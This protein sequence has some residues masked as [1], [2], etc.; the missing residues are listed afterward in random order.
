MSD[1]ENADLLSDISRTTALLS[2]HVGEAETLLFWLDA[3]SAEP[4]VARAA[5]GRE[6]IAVA[7]RELRRLFAPEQINCRRPEHT[8][9]MRWLTPLGH[10]LLQPVAERLRGCRGLVVAPHGELHALHLHLLAPP[11]GVPLGITHAITYA[12]NLSLYALLLGRGAAARAAL[13]PSLC[14]ATAARE[15]SALVRES[16]ALAPRS[17]AERTGG[18]F[19]EGSDATWAALRSHVSKANSIYLSCHGCFNEQDS[20]K[21]FLL[22]SDGA[23]LPSKTEAN[24]ELHELS[25]RDI[26]RLRLSARLVILDACLSGL[27]HF[28]PGDE[29]MG[30]PTAFLLAGADAVIAS[31]WR[32]EQNCARSFMLALQ[33]HWAG[34]SATLGEAMRQAYTATQAEYPH[35]FH[36]AAFSLFGN[37]RLLFKS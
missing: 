22:L 25:V 9:D 16:F 24:G 15:D 2:F 18:L 32:V 14:L 34:N 8:T 11:D 3:D 20:L 19:L 12:A 26:L 35:A 29:P 1:E 6:E 27:Q 37:D 30:F 31:N 28:A 13:L 17:Y 23:N 21:S 4:Q 7:A 5:V 33:A 36:W 10:R